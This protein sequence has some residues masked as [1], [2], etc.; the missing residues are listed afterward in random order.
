MARGDL[1]GHVAYM[2]HLDGSR[3]IDHHPMTAENCSRSDEKPRYARDDKG[4]GRDH[5]SNESPRGLASP[6][7]VGLIL[8]A[9]VGAHDGQIRGKR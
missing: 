1:T 4:V 5:N 9:P 6:L 3:F 8:D 7:H 2:G